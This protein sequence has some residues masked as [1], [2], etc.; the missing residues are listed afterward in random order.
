MATQNKDF[1]NFNNEKFQAGLLIMMG[2][3][4]A[5]VFSICIR[6]LTS[7]EAFF[8]DLFAAVFASI[9]IIFNCMGAIRWQRENQRIQKEE[10]DLAEKKA[11]APIASAN[12]TAMAQAEC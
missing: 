9:A 8:S 12:S 10:E 1:I 2:T 4:F 11:I 6:P 7:A 5:F 3:M